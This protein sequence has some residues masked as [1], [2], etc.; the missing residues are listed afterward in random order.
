MKYSCVLFDLDNTLLV[1]K[2]TIPEEI[3]SILSKYD[4]SV[5]R[6]IVDKL[7]ADAELWVGNQTKKENETGVRM[8]DEEFLDNILS[9]YRNGLH[10]DDSVSQELLPILSHATPKTYAVMSGAYELLEILA[11]S[12]MKLGIVS[13]NYSDIRDV[14]STFDLSKYFDSIVI[15]EEVRLWKP[16]PAILQLACTELG[17]SPEE[18]I[19]V[20]DHPFDIL[21]AHS[22]GM[23]TAWFPPNP[24]YTVPGYCEKPEYTIDGLQDL[25]SILSA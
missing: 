1:K 15:S 25:I 14:L 16:D 2:P 5:T 12:K 9:I 10:F 23:A 3:F 20:G 21:C 17:V 7:Y 4:P 13:N 6:E 19:Y 24:Y 11:D 18:T 22:A 8:P